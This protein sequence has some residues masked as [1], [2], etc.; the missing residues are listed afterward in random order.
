MKIDQERDENFPTMD[1]I[2]QIHIFLGGRWWVCFENCNI[3][4]ITR[5]LKLYKLEIR[6]DIKIVM[7]YSITHQTTHLINQ[8]KYVTYFTITC[9]DW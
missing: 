2:N 4:D 3:I 8:S 6:Y 9:T 5:S 7:Q 1:W